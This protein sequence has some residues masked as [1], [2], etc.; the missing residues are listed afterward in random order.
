MAFL[1]RGQILITVNNYVHVKK[2]ADEKKR[3]K[4]CFQK[5]LKA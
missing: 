4:K 1:V 5:Y 3:F 2:I